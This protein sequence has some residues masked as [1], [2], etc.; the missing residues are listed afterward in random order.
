MDFRFEY[1]DQILSF[2]TCLHFRFA[3]AAF[4]MASK[5][6]KDSPSGDTTAFYVELSKHEKNG[7]YDKALKICNKILN[8][9]PKDQVAFHCKMVCLMK[10]STPKFD[11][12]LRQIRDT[13]FTDLDLVFEE[14]Y[15][16]YRLNRPEES[17]VVL[18]GYN[19]AKTLPISS[20]KL[21]CKPSS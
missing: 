8:V 6:H 18:D 15:C 16:L 11:E 12:D 3:R 5:G 7:E 19:K 9:T 17:L 2:P 1:T 13:H 21:V 20:C 14:A 4:I 10:S